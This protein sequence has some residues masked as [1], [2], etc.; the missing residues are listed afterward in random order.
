MNE[1]SVET[2]SIAS[3]GAVK[4]H[5]KRSALALTSFILAWFILIGGGI[6]GAK[7]YTEHIQEQITSDVEQQ[8]AAQITQMQQAYDTRIDD[9][10]SGYKAEI[11]ALNSKIDALNELLNFTKDNADDK[12][13]NSNKL[14]TQLNEVKKQLDEL[15]KG[16]DVLK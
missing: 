16:L 10:E 2:P 4:T 9:V 1:I 12:T 11:A 3:R 13:D 15:K 6:Y 8:T 7:V 14:Y 5:R